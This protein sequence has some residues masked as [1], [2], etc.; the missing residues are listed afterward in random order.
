VTSPN[1]VIDIQSLEKG[2]YRRSVR[3]GYGT[4]KSSLLRLFSRSSDPATTRQT[5]LDNLTLRIPKGA[6][7][8][9]IGK[10]GSGKSTLLKLITGIYKA[11][12]GSL[13]VSGRIAALIELGA[14][15]HPD[16][17][18]R[19]NLYLSAAMHGLKR[20]EI[21]S[22]F[23][24]IVSFAEL[25]D[26][27]DDPVRTYSS[28]MYMRLGFSIAIHT[29]PDILIVDE[30]LAVGDARFVSKCK[31]KLA[32]MRREGRT[33]LLVTHDLDAVNRWCDEALWLHEGVVKERGNPRRV[34][35]AYLEF[36]ESEESKEIEAR[37]IEHQLA[38]ETS[39]EA[40]EGDSSE[41]Y[42]RWGSREIEIV[43]TR[44]V[45]NSGDA[46][47]V[48][49][50]DDEL[51]VEL[52]YLL[53]QEDLEGV[54][55]GVGLNRSDGI[56]LLGTNTDIEEFKVPKLQDSGTVRFKISRLGLLEGSYSVDV[57]AHRDDGYPFDYHKGAMEFSVRTSKPYVG[58]FLPQ[59][60][61][62]IE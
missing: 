36:V 38:S 5:V 54:V 41:R 25:E 18:G 34:I 57:A 24:E 30:V 47:Q 8:G 32:D 17:S 9:I 62:E 40:S 26:V 21:D 28:G 19:E 27:I 44:I 45:G 31:D 59:H 1:Y 53:H 39:D 3:K 13:K 43:S 23:K 12:K 60:S 48:F 49:H 51:T 42:E 11:D 14:G 29:D 58:V 16:F 56:T 33:L 61:W 15:F 46:K 6:S 50:P 35:D 4:I 20:E 7:V 2:F 22:R 52:D 55:F 10:N 37:N